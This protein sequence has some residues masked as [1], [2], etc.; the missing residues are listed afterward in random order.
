MPQT[1]NRQRAAALHEHEHWF[2]RTL[3][4]STHA[5]A[6]ASYSRLGSLRGARTGMTAFTVMPSFASS[7]AN[8]RTCR[9]P[10]FVSSA[11]QLL[12]ATRCLQRAA[13]NALPATRCSH[14]DAVCPARGQAHQVLKAGFG[15][16]GRL[17]KEAGGV[18]AAVAACA[19]AGAV[20]ALDG[21]QVRQLPSQEHQS[22]AVIK[23]KQPHTG[24]QNIL[25]T[26]HHRTEHMNQET[27]SQ[28]RACSSAANCASTAGEVLARG[29]HLRSLLPRPV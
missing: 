7:L 11:R 8:T 22:S 19:M 5:S 3:Q 21:S 6:H 1:G 12:P 20:S 28:A 25:N 24:A 18:L 9:R 15:V 2:S 27:Q 23:P 14:A 10:L 17:I 13:C 16:A 4:P 29:G 26:P